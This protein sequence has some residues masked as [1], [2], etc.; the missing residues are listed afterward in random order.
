MKSKKCKAFLVISLFS[1][2]IIL[3]SS[4]KKEGAGPESAKDSQ[5]SQLLKQ[6]GEDYWD[7]LLE[8]S[9]YLRM[10]H[11]LQI[12]KLPDITY[13]HAQSEIDF[14]TSLMEKLEAVIPKELCHEESI[15]L[16]ILKWELKNAVDGFPYFWFGFP[17]TPYSSPLSLVH[18]V[19]TEFKFESDSDCNKYMNLLRQYAPFVKS[20]QNRLQKQFTKGIIVPKEEL[21]VVVPYLNMF[22]SEGKKSLFFVP[23][24]RLDSL[25]EGTT[26]TFQEDVAN[27]VDSEIKPALEELVAYI[28]GVYKAN[29]SITVGL[30]QYPEGRDYYRY[31]I[32]V[33]TTLGLS[34]EEIHEIGLQW[35]KK[36]REEV[37]KI[38]QSV[39][40]EGTFDEF[41]HFLRT[42]PRFF[43]KTA[44]EI[45]ERLN[46]YI[47]GMEEKLDDYF[48]WKPKAPYGVAR[49]APELE[50]SMTFGYYDAPSAAN[51]K[52]IYYYNGSTPE[53]RSLLMS[54]GL[55]Y[56][57]LIPGHH[58]HIASQTENE[59]LPAFRRETLHN[60]FNE[61][62]AEYASWLAMEAGLYQDPYSRAGKYMMDMFLSVRLVVDTGMNFLEW[63]RLKAMD[64]MRENV[65]ETETQIQSETLRYSVDIPAQALGYK[66]GSIKMRELRD[67]AEK[68]LGDTFDIRK[69]NDALL[70]SGSMPF[71]VLEKHIDWFIAKELER[72]EE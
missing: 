41:R 61:G 23:L 57:E 14:A 45:G 13:E 60:A 34:P 43:P 56:H 44:D 22:V 69:F 6:I 50:G 48:L 20:I 46:S 25:E 16:D 9:L 47:K 39:S 27:L 64:F 42:D 8:E 19:F 72:S 37:D 55:L 59:S 28:E 18:R 17:I 36:N 21:D 5:S 3:F 51:P 40:F 58:F 71:P 29:A 12:T 35:V 33:Q 31:L 30:W 4:C 53:K 63:T 7:H 66:L 65:L 15:T 38:R 52:G 54:E 70:G 2:L 10:K 1:T 26:G 62:W 49:L 68:A 67:K 24:E 11:G 32:R